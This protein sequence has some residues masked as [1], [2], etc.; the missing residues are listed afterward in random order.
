MSDHDPVPGEPEP[1]VVPA[2]PEFPID[3]DWIAPDLPHMVPS[4]APPDP[5]RPHRPIGPPRREE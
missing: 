4:V 3:P 2:P 5:S 1:P